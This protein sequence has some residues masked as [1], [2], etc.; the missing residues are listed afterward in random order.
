[1]KK[2]I[3]SV[4]SIISLVILSAIL[5]G[6]TLITT[7]EKYVP[8]NY[9]GSK[10]E[11]E[12]PYIRLQIPK[13]VKEIAIAITEKNGNEISFFL[14]MNNRHVDAIRYHDDNNDCIEITDSDVLFSGMISYSKDSFTISINKANDILFDGEYDSLVF[15]R[16]Q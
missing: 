9:P 13:D 5:T 2:A 8:F 4:V 7:A 14:G 10:W 12:E 16:T 3:V 6:C 11:C 1:M 15:K